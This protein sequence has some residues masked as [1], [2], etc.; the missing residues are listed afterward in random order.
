[1]AENKV[2]GIHVAATLD[3]GQFVEG[4]R[5]V[6]AESKKTEAVVKSSFSG[7][8]TAIKGFGGALTA[9]LS[10]GLL[11]GLAKKALDFAAA[12][13]TTAKQ[14]GVTTKELQTFRYAADQVGIKNAEADK[15]LERLGVTMGKAAAGSKSAASALGAVGVTLTDIKTKTR[16]E[17]FAQIADQMIRQ[18]G[19]AK[20][21]AA[22]TAVFGQGASKLTPL[23]DKGSQG[24]SQLSA[25]A[26]RLGIVLSDQQIQNADVTAQK[27]DDVKQVLE[28]Q[29]AG[30]VAENATSIISLANALGSLT[31]SIINFLGSNPQAALGIIGALAGSRLGVTGAAAGGIVGLF[32]GGRIAANR[33]AT[34]SDVGFLKQR[35]QKESATLRK[36][37]ESNKRGAA[38]NLVPQTQKVWQLTSRLESA[39]AGSG[40]PAAVGTLPIPQFLAGA[41]K[42][43]RTPRAARG[44]RDRSDDVA[45]QFEQE[46]RRA[47]MDILRAKQA[48]ARDYSDRT[49]IAMLILDLEKQ[50]YEAELA[51]K[52]RRAQRDH[53]EGKIT[54][55]TLDQ[56]TAQ[57]EVL[58]AKNAEADTLKRRAVIEEEIERTREDYARIEQN[59][60]GN[61]RELLEAQAQL[62]TTAAE[63]RD[64]ELR[65]LDLAYREEKARLERIMRESKDWAEIEMA[66]QDLVNLNATYGANQEAVRRANRNPLEEWAASIPQTVP[67]I[68]EA[69]QA[70]QA[71]GLDSLSDAIADVIT[72]TK[73]LKDAFGDVAKSI[74]ADLIRMSVRMLIF[75]ALSSAFGG[76]FGAPS[77]SSFDYSQIGQV[78]LPGFKDGGSLRILGRT[79]TDRNIVSINNVPV[80]R[81]NYG[82][83]M[84]FD[85]DNSSGGGAVT[86]NQT[87]QFEGV[88]LTQEEFMRGLMLTK[89]A[90]I[91][92]I[93]EERR[94]A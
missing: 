44:P 70:I 53:A 65:I 12:I 3:A 71:Q 38:L 85:N 2:A 63:R 89:T 18:G 37:V 5:K 67:Q 74:I 27:L 83:R 81:A 82:E 76:M 25:A 42:K 55:D 48:L 23:L 39:V 14:L 31:S 33:D 46:Q 51:D 20:N 7:M 41:P 90:T 77:S 87:F 73:S 50:G 80:A 64:I 45:F 52:V 21:A 93:K 40:S 6:Q 29:I 13:G 15:G 24:I 22:A 47:E 79:G 57:A 54:K 10:I 26:E 36:F 17:I 59:A 30:V 34:S 66:R 58:K 19:A 60:F 86:V 61:Q 88:A 16:T 28:A 72:G 78:D 62:A 1:M 35:L 92:A 11:G 69:F 49:S 56:V 8:G 94:R 75:R 84:I 32:A 4:A 9:G 68:I 43:G 91:A